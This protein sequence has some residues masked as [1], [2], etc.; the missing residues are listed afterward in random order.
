VIFERSVSVL[1]CV[2]KISSKLGD[3]PRFIQGWQVFPSS[4][5]KP[6]FSMEKT[7]PAKIV[8]AG[9]KKPPGKNPATLAL[10][11]FTKWKQ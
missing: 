11:T 8:F 4:W 5:K 2:P 7:V 6:V 1:V 10:Q 9:L 3:N